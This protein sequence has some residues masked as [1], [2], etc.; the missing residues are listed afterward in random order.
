MQQ[1]NA[2]IGVAEAAYFPD[3]SLSSMMQYRRPH[4]AAVQRR[5]FDR[6]DRRERDADACSMAA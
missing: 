2:L 4:S 3:I 1:Q 5:A 6:V